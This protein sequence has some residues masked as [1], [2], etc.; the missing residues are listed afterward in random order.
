ML[1]TLEGSLTV[2]DSISSVTW[3]RFAVIVLLSAGAY[4]AAAPWLGC[5]VLLPFWRIDAVMLSVCTFGG[6]PFRASYGVPGFNGPYWG[7]L[8]VGILYLAAVVLVAR[9]RRPL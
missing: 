6:I 2:L 9:R 5:V 3:A 4:F 1:D 8:V 7:S